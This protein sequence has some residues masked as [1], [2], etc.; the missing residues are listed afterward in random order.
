MQEISIYFINLNQS[1]YNSLPTQSYQE[2]EKSVLALFET[3]SLFLGSLVGTDGFLVQAGMVS[4]RQCTLPSLPCLETRI[5]ANTKSLL[6][7]VSPLQIFPM[8]SCHPYPW[9]SCQAQTHILPLS[10]LPL[11][12]PKVLFQTK[13]LCTCSLHNPLNK[14]RLAQTKARKNAFMPCSKDSVK[15]RESQNGGEWNSKTSFPFI[16]FHRDK[17]K[18][19]N[20]LCK[21]FCTF[22]RAKLSAIN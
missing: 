18:I 6:L 3:S 16:S 9:G 14:L 10:L 1:K 20:R 11:M 12:T 8:R 15:R 5:F 22:M 19:Q 17:N 2:G 7:K 4:W 13:P 21:L